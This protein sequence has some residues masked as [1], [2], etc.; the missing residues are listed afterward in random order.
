MATDYAADRSQEEMSPR[1]GR[2]LRR[3]YQSSSTNNNKYGAVTTTADGVRWEEPRPGFAEGGAG[4]SCDTLTS[5]PM[6]PASKSL[7]IKNGMLFICLFIII[8][9]LPNFF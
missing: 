9:G 7:K 5:F 4:R 2:W 6:K 1:L 3:G 8:Y